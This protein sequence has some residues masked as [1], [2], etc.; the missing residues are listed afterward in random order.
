[1]MSARCLLFSAIAALLSLPNLRD[2]LPLR[3]GPVALNSAQP[4]ALQ[5]LSGRVVDRTGRPLPGAAVCAWQ[6]GTPDWRT[7]AGENG[8][9]QV[10]VADPNVPINLCVLYPGYAMLP[11]QVDSLR[12][13]TV[14]LETGAT[15]NG[16]VLSYN[17]TPVPGAQVVAVSSANVAL[18]IQTSADESGTFQMSNVPT[19]PYAF[20][21]FSPNERITRA[22]LKPH[23][24]TIFSVSDR[25]VISGLEL[26]LRPRDS[27]APATAAS[28]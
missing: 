26:Y 23:P 15:V 6:D 20:Y 9:F 17:G 25:Q 12:D 8:R 19:G 22:H 24:F 7:Q 10:G 21:I 28:P 3:D 2:T 4:L 18:W 5:Y 13:I 14:T 16:T 11:A 27:V 1:M